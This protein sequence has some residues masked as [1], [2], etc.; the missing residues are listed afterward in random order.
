MANFIYE[1]REELKRKNYVR[2][3]SSNQ[4]YWFDIYKRRLRNYTTEYGDKFNI[5]L[6][7]S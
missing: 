1:N 5:I 2:K 4:D 3:A 7:R 6:Y